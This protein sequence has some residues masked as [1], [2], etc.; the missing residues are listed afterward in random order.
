MIQTL[1]LAAWYQGLRLGPMRKNM[2]TDH[3]DPRHPH[4][5]MNHVA[6]G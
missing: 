5:S 2:E 1:D 6:A 4:A 3:D